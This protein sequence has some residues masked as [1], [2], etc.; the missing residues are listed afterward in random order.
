MGRLDG[1]V[2]VISGAARG[3]G[4]AHATTLAREGA[5]IVA[6]DICEPLKHPLTPGAT[7]EQLQETARLVEEHDQRCLTAKAD[8][9]D[10]PALT[11][12]ADQAM[13]EFGRVDIVV[14]N[15]GIWVVEPNSWDLD[16]DSW[17][18]SIDVLLTGAWKVT[19]A[20]APKIIA[21]QRGGAIVLTG[22]V[23][24]VQAQPGAIAYVAAKHGVAGIMKVLAHELGPH[25]IR[26]NTVNPGG[27][28][29]P[30]LLEGGTIDKAAELHPK[31]ISHNRALLPVEWIEP[32][33][34]A[35]AVLWL[36][37][38]EAK[39]VTGAM[40]PVDSGWVNG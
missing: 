15:H 35:D 16:E 3:Q 40:I 21:G 14:V 24:S 1:K 25:W 5:S 31:Y 13:S 7:E 10:L 20:F 33:T 39:N 36:V 11:K 4:R 30:M 37:S 28:A 19:K 6:F 26:V 38:D 2:A 34:V 8:A 29:T 22:S 23:N 18:E 32:Q 17:Q 9:R 12:L 27:I